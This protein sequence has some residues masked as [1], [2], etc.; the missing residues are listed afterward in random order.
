MKWKVICLVSSNISSPASKLKLLNIPHRS[1][2]VVCENWRELNKI[3]LEQVI[4]LISSNISPPVS[5]VNTY[6]C[7]QALLETVCKNWRKL[8]KVIPLGG[9]SLFSFLQYLISGI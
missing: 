4:C 9:N 5:K 8:N 6:K 1:L 2:K 7:L 3:D